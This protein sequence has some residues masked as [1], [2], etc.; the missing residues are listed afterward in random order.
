[1][2]STTSSLLP[3]QQHTQRHMYRTRN[4]DLMPSRRRL[5]SQAAA[6][7]ASR[8]PVGT[9]DVATVHSPSTSRSAS[10]EGQHSTEAHSVR[11][12]T[13]APHPTNPILQFNPQAM[14]TAGQKIDITT[15]SLAEAKL[16][17]QNKRIQQAEAA[18][19]APLPLDR[20]RQTSRGK[21]KQWKLFDLTASVTPSAEESGV[22]LPRPEVR[23]NT[24]R[25]ST[26]DSS[27]SRSMSSLSQRTSNTAASDAER[28]DSGGERGGFQLFTGRKGKRT[29]DQLSAYSDQPEERQT[30]V[31]ATFDERE[32]YHVFGNALPAPD[33]IEQN[34]GSKNGELKFVQHPN[35]DV[36]AHQW[37]ETRYIWENIG[38]FS[39]I[40]KK[41]EGQLGS[42]RLKGETAYQTLQQ[43]TLAYFRIIA[44]QR[45]AGV[46]GSP[47]GTKDIQAALPDSRPTSASVNVP[48]KTTVDPAPQQISLAPD[49]QTKSAR[50]ELPAS[51]YAGRYN[52]AAFAYD[53][54]TGLGGYGGLRYDQNNYDMQY[55]PTGPRATQ[56]QRN[57]AA[58]AGQM[59]DPFYA[60]SSYHDV[61]GSHGM[62]QPGYRRLSAGYGYR[63]G[64]AERPQLNYDLHYPPTSHVAQAPQ[65]VG[66]VVDEE[67]WPR[68]Q[69]RQTSRADQDHAQNLIKREEESTNMASPL[70]A[71]NTELR[72][73]K[74]Y[75]L[76]A[77]QPS[78]SHDTST[79]DLAGRSSETGGVPTRSRGHG[80]PVAVPQLKTFTPLSTRNS[81]RDHLLRLGDQ[82]KNR[83]LSHANLRSVMYGPF[84]AS[85]S[86][87]STKIAEQT[88]D[89]ESPRVYRTVANPSGILP[90]PKQT[91]QD[92]TPIKPF[93]PTVGARRTANTSA[94]MVLKEV[95]PE[96]AD[97]SSSYNASF[98]QAQ[99][100]PQDFK[101]PFFDQTTTAADWSQALSKPPTSKKGIDDELKDWWTSG[102]TFQRHEDF[103][104]SLKPSTNDPTTQNSPATLAPIGTP[105][106]KPLPPLSSTDDP[107]TRLLI[108]VLENL[109]S[110]V[111]GPAE[112][113]QDYFSRW[114]QPAEWCI[115]RSPNGN[116]SFF[117]SE[118]GQPP[119]RI[120]RDARYRPL[121]VESVRFGAFSSPQGGGSM[122]VGSGVVG[123]DRR[124]A[125][126]GGGRK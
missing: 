36:S 7:P 100:T 74:Q 71:I 9:P 66:A 112:K 50:H 119:A 45:E 91:R 82:A 62:A 18:L 106:K 69:P 58:M 96:Y 34:V 94:A 60:A 2:E 23:I 37:S 88:Q 40:R 29:G 19:A 67:S 97:M 86:P 48:A 76:D 61:Y 57:A 49:V 26:R 84:Q 120:G 13:E 105:A 28:Q 44:K 92:D 73:R 122:A 30:T 8:L 32:V 113:R 25:A 123:L 107:M 104:R 121:P 102:N 38:Q 90:T 111:Q 39:N 53:G 78:R 5:I 21:G 99:P 43:N 47:F 6:L 56:H 115:D 79:Q 68:L 114:S 59:Y 117:D 64:V 65:K 101:R 75:G 4:S 108:P 54:Y 72:A 103:Y 1:M 98:S 12:T 116:N 87:T 33:F 51:E 27:M 63:A 35:G 124:F 126:G 93:T 95:S 11:D 31:E 22:A 89:D 70:Q 46:M 10:S 17:R 109:A 24:F 52:A 81:M 125:F 110:Y 83:S 15:M 77:A 20:D 3:A 42:D 118:W 16:A 41:I 14:A 85:S 55:V 80:T